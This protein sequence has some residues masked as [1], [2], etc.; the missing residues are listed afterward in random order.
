MRDK[1][2]RGRAVEFSN[3]GGVGAEVGEGIAEQNDRGDEGELPKVDDAEAAGKQGNEQDGKRLRRDAGEEEVE[4]VALK[5]RYHFKAKD[6]KR[7]KFI[8]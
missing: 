3:E 1:L 4:G 5:A 2:R 8:G 6:T 7:A